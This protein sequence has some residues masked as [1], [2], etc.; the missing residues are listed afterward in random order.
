MMT[1]KGA[2][3]IFSKCFKQH[4]VRFNQKEKMSFFGMFQILN[5]LSMQSQT[6]W[7]PLYVTVYTHTDIYEKP[8]S[9]KANSQ[10]VV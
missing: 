4:I 6:F 5:L 7:I 10:D 2:L 9:I 8:S 1:F 3:R